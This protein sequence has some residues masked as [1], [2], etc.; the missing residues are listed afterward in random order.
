[1]YI[2][3]TYI[4]FNRLFLGVI[5]RSSH[6]NRFYYLT[7]QSLFVITNLCYTIMSTGLYILSLILSVNYINLNFKLVLVYLGSGKI[8]NIDE[9][10]SRFYDLTENSNNWVRRTCNAYN[11]YIEKKFNWFV[12]LYRRS[13]LY[14]YIVELEK[15]L[16]DTNTK[17]LF[18]R[19]NDY[20][21]I[22]RVRGSLPIVNN[23]NIIRL[24]IIIRIL[25]IPIIINSLHQ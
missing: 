18:R 13:V 24:R 25:S 12:L 9:I 19:R 23:D 7:N 5:C 22:W 17:I 15:Y 16:I 10:H 14:F 21:F 20:C 8:E 2:L 1:M 6:A 4:F 3:A 11:I